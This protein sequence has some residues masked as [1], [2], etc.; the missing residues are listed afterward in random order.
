M[1][2]VEISSP[3]FSIGDSDGDSDAEEVDV[4]N[5]G[6][7]RATSASP[8]AGISKQTSLGMGSIA[9]ALSRM[10]TQPLVGILTEDQLGDSTAVGKIVKGSDGVVD[11]LNINTEENGLHETHGLTSPV[12][13]ASRAWVEEEGEIFRKGT[14]LRVAD[15]EEIEENEGVPGD[16]L[17]QEVSVLSP[18]S[19]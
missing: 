14:I 10:D 7:S 11:D 9:N 12:E 2:S 19:L 5:F 16:E 15:D 3:N 17:R 6:N 13:K 1:S 8:S 4:G 18:F